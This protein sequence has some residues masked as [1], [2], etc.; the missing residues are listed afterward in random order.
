MSRVQKDKHFFSDT[1]FG[2]VLGA[3]IG[4]AVATVHHREKAASRVTFLPVVSAE[5]VGLLVSV[6]Y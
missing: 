4:H 3:V 6:R 5:T 2:A 1:L